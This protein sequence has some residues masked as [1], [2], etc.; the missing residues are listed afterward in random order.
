MIQN[1]DRDIIATLMSPE[2]YLHPVHEVRVI[3]THISWVLLA[4]DFAYKIK[5]SVDFGFLDFS[6]LRKRRYY[7][8]QEVKLNRRLCDDLYLGVEPIRE[9]AGTV[10]V[11]GRR[12]RIVEYAVKMKRLPEDCLLENLLAADR[13]TPGMIES[14]AVKLSHFHQ[15]AETGP[16]I[17]RFGSARAICR[18]WDENFEQTRD[19]IGSTIS[20]F[21]FEYLRAWV[22]ASM[23][24][25]RELF[26]RRV[27]GGRIRDG[28]GDLRASAICIQDRLCIFDCIEF[29]RRFRYAD[30][31]ADVAFLA[32]D[33][34]AKGRPDL[35]RTFIDAYVQHSGDREL[36][37]VIDFYICYRAYVRGKV[38][39]FRTSEANISPAEYAESQSIARERF[40]L[41]VE[42]AARSQPPVLLITCGLSGSGKST[43]AGGVG[44][45]FGMDIIASDVVRKELAGRTVTDRQPVE[46]EAGIYAPEHTRRT[47]MAMMSRAR[48]RLEDGHS[49]ILDATF[50]RREWRASALDVARDAGALFLCLE[51]RS[52]EAE[53]RRRLDARDQESGAVSEATWATYLS[54]RRTFEPVDELSDWQHVVLD[55]GAELDETIRAAARSLDAR[56]RP[57]PVDSPTH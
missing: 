17:A 23:R 21:Q 35:S 20:P 56:L 22:D 18:N 42:A 52:N 9:Y 55:T 4:G 47:Y 14:I 7:C 45:E 43:V 25:N 8:D 46:F 13:V 15:T 49:A 31:A 1:D 11:G 53:T 12:G 44:D 24:R 37:D 3:Q 6:T 19:Y 28:H 10:E 27:A 50:S 33:L 54:Q 41:A 40:D 2:V 36:L 39:G 38:E 30:V 26:K 34:T 29:N 57:K 16:E 5:K 51:C 32:M 48:S